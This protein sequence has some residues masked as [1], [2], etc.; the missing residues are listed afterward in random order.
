MTNP[1]EIEIGDTVKISNKSGHYG[2]GTANPMGEGISIPHKDDDW[3]YRVLWPDGQTN[4][5]KSHDLI[6]IKKGKTM[7]EFTKLD[8]IKLAQTET[9]FIK[10][11]NGNFKIVLGYDICGN[12]DKWGEINDY[13]VN[14]NKRTGN[15]E[16]DIVAVYKKGIGSSLTKYLKGQH[17]T[18]IWERT[19]QTPA[20]KEMEV[21]QVKMNE[22]QEQMKVVQAKL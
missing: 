12:D 16:F 7:K 5:Y 11:R 2:C 3:P 1:L 19:E 6:L 20:Q 22:L 8:L 14:M 9:V 4:S 13:S 17:L 18:L 15:D 21:L 10:Q